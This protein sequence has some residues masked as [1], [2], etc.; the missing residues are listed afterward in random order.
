MKTNYASLC[1]SASKQ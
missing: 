1:A